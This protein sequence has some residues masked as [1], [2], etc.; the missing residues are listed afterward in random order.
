M[1]LFAIEIRKDS[2]VPIYFQIQ[3][4]ITALIE[5]GILRP[6]ECLPSENV[7]AR[8]F[9]ISPMTVRQAM[10][11]LVNYGYVYRQ[12][13]RGTF[14]ATR[15]MEHPLER[16]VSFSEDMRSRGL[17]SSSQI[18]YF[19]NVIPPSEVDLR[20]H[21]PPDTRLTRIKRLRFA[22]G[23]PVGIHDSYLHNVVISALELEKKHSL[24]ALLAEKGTHLGEGEDMIEAVAASKE[25][26]QLLNVKTGSPLLRTTR[27]AWDVHGQFVEYVVALYHANLYQY[28]TRLKR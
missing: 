22:D 14:V 10:T 26:A 3:T 9:N 11:E 5:S 25:A 15:R 27:F 24:Y 12:R 20:I 19:E 1:N 16:L 6:G 2:P 18:L 21:L 4:G 28:R 13:G 17:S 23:K 8:R 7:L